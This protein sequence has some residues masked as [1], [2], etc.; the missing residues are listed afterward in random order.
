MHLIHSFIH[1]F[2]LSLR[3]QIMPI[4]PQTL[5]YSYTSHGGK[6]GS[7]K[8]QRA[9]SPAAPCED[10][11]IARSLW[12][13]YFLFCFDV[14]LR[15][16]EK[17]RIHPSN[18]GEGMCCNRISTGD[19]SEKL[20][21]DTSKKPTSLPKCVGEVQVEELLPWQNAMSEM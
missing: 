17:Q 10:E 21:W 19:C 3:Y 20:A 6:L 16:K 15:R 14:S 5:H 1:F 8:I 18:C 12:S 11:K 9:R 7:Y 2:F 13:E 4:C